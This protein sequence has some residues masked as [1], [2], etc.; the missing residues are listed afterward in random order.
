MN[1]PT[2]CDDGSYCPEGSSVQKQCPAGYY[3]VDNGDSTTCEMGYYCMA[4]SMA[5]KACP[6]NANCP[7][8]STANP[9]LMKLELSTTL[10]MDVADFIAGYQEAF[11]ASVAEWL[12]ATVSTDD[13]T[14]LCMCDTSC[15]ASAGVTSAGEACG[16][17]GAA[18]RRSLQEVQEVN[19]T[20]IDYEVLLGSTAEQRGVLATAKGADAALGLQASLAANGFDPDVAQSATVKVYTQ[21]ADGLADL[22]YTQVLI[23]VMFAVPVAML[24]VGLAM[25]QNS[26]KERPVKLPGLISAVVLTFYDFFSDV[27]FAATPLPPDYVGFTIAASVAVG[28]ATLVGIGI[29]AYSLWHHEVAEWG[30]VD[31]VTVVLAVTNTDLLALLPWVGASDAYEGMPDRTTAQLPVM[32]VV[33]ED[34]PQLFIQGIYLITSGDTGNVVVLVS[35]SMSGCSLLL[36]FVRGA[37]AFV[38]GGIESNLAETSP[39]RKWDVGRLSEWLSGLASEDP[40]LASIVQRTQGASSIDFLRL[41]DA[42]FS[43][44]HRLLAEEEEEE[45]EKEGERD[46]NKFTKGEVAS[47]AM[48]VLSA[49]L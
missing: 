19:I 30:A 18:R 7:P 14:I 8:G 45:E 6:V 44:Q 24:V 9:L 40:T 41:V 48:S 23:T 37:F 10:A 13:V 28:V 1:E 12:G 39:M 43:A 46:R 31:V 16:A 38:K 29:V 42:C 27:W 17:T 21:E 35:V 2:P 26:K 25:Y 11:R 20:S 5:P 22:D 3:C 33:V 49:S 47:S 34:L 36:R 15:T 32:G 4:G